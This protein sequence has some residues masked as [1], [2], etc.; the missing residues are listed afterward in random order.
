MP[1]K[2]YFT[3]MTP[4]MYACQCNSKIVEILLPLCN[5][6]IIEMT[7][8]NNNNA[9]MIAIKSKHTESAKMILSRKD[10]V[11][12]N[13]I[14]NPAQTPLICAC[15]CKN[16]EIVKLILSNPLHNTLN[17][18]NDKQSTTL[19]YASISGNLPIVK[20]ILSYIDHDS[21]ILHH[22]NVDN[23]NALFLALSNN[24]VKIAK[25]LMSKMDSYDINHK[26]NCNSSS[27]SYGQEDMTKID[28]D[29]IL[30]ALKKGY[31][32]TLTLTEAVHFNPKYPEYQ[33][34]YISNIKDKYA[35]YYDGKNWTLTMKEELIEKIYEDKKSYIEEN[36]DDFVNSLTDSR[37]NALDRWLNTDEEDDK[38]KEIKGKIRLLLYNKR[39]LPIENYE[40]IKK[41]NAELINKIKISKKK[42]I[43]NN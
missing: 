28:N 30:N 41:D 16:Y 1:L 40:I 27:L 19:M 29:E 8:I 12:F 33:N 38:I 31:Y 14:S 13:S 11:S 5:K 2:D 6:K 21:E 43:K 35:M 24:H 7:D 9:L 4:L 3:G 25:I 20:L 37:K 22:N 36:L 23:N 34:V 15:Q 10:H 26:N 32:S 18:V 39:E 17:Y 42:T